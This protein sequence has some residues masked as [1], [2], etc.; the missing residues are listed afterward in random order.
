[1]IRALPAPHPTPLH[2]VAASR[3]IEAQALAAS[4]PQALM[5]AAGQ[6]VARL[7]QALAPHAPCFWVLAGPGNNGGDGLGA[8]LAL[9]RAGHRVGVTWLGDAT[10]LPADAAD[11]HAR[12]TAG[13]VPLH[14]NFPPLPAGSLVIDALLGLGGLRAPE[15]R[16]AEAIHA[17]NQRTDITVLAIDLPSGLNADTGQPLGTPCVVA[18]HTLSL[19]T[20]KPGL[21]TG[22]GRDL[23]GRVWQDTLGQDAL[24][25]ATPATAQLT[26]TARGL[27]RHRAHNSN[28][29]SHGDVRVLGG[30]PGM[31]GAAWLAGRAALTA[32]AGRVHVHLLDDAAPALDDTRPEL[33]VRH[34]ADDEQI[35]HWTRD[36]VVCG[37]GGSTVVTPLLPAVLLHASRLVLDADALNALAAQ[38]DGAQQLAA[39]A[40]RGQATVLTPHPLE[41]A[42]WLACSAAQVQAHRLFA[43]QTLADRTQCTVL[44]KGS[45]TVIAAPGRTPWIN[46]S[47][48]AALATA[49]TGDVL[50]GWLGGLWAQVAAGSDTA[51]MSQNKPFD[52]ALDIA[53]NT[54]ITAAYQHGLAADRQTHTVLRAADLVEAL[55]ALG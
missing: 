44:L 14:S 36:V 39:R 46:S 18:Q 3:L 43:A 55:G 12:A 47:G 9:H 11:A 6:A 19:L 49:G 41:A 7:A 23:A 50:A 4:A 24:L 30:A 45:G 29:G 20:L 10:R 53:F 31:V 16:L 40:A 17:L 1:M 13:G 48:N 25:S 37:C 15:G 52:I 2:G 51:D 42:R 26:G 5:H 22:Q 33:M 21:F 28:K 32:G 35:A 34:G 8:A 54:A 27:R 38:A